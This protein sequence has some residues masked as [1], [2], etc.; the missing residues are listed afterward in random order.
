MPSKKRPAQPTGIAAAFSGLRDRF[1]TRDMEQN[2]LPPE[3]MPPDEL[4]RRSDEELRGLIA[5]ACAILEAR[6]KERREQ[7][8]A[9]IHR[10]AKDH[11]LTVSLSEAPPKRKRGR[12]RKQQASGTS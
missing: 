11:G 6:E 12:P 3:A 7:A 8:R 10:I 2:T 9:E 4:D 1:T 5:R